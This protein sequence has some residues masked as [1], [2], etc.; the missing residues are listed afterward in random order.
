[1]GRGIAFVAESSGDV[2][3]LPGLACDPSFYRLELMGQPLPSV[4]VYAFARPTELAEA[5]DSLTLSGARTLPAD[6]PADLRAAYLATSDDVYGPPGWLL[7]S[8]L[9]ARTVLKTLRGA[10]H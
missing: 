8:A 10:L 6:A 5:L 4:P 2:V 9:D 1:M 3:A 7:C